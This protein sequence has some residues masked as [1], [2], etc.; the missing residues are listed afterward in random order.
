MVNIRPHRKMEVLR[1]KDA[2]GR[3]MVMCWTCHV[4]A[5]A[6]DEETAKADLAKT[7]CAPDCANCLQLRESC[8]TTPAVP[9]GGHDY[10]LTHVCPNDGNRWWQS[11]DHLHTWQQVTSD[12]EWRIINS[13]P[14]I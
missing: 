7:S 6:E 12:E 13:W 8:A 4:C 10:D 14:R 9:L 3:T 2:K 11:N 5:G 1:L